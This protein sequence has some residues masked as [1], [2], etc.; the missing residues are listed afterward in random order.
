MYKTLVVVFSDPKLGSEE[1]LGKL[2]NAMFLVYELK[3]KKQEVG[4]IFQ[5]TGTR[6]LGEV[7]KPDHAAHGLY[8]SVKDKVV[9]ASA[10]CATVF[11]AVEAVENADTQL[12]KDAAIPGTPGVADIS[13][14][15]LGGYQIVAL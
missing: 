10:G 8:N 11:G 2:F 6:W 7:V 12:L 15:I 5:G 4:L 1:A 3:E 13:Q 9:G 14:Y